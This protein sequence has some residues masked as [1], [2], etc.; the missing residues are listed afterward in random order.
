[1]KLQLTHL[2]SVERV[3]RLERSMASASLSGST[4]ELSWLAEF[5]QLSPA[6]SS[7][8]ISPD[9]SCIPKASLNR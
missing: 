1:M 5:P 4:P 6:A 3:E 7:A 2:Y 9:L 8:D